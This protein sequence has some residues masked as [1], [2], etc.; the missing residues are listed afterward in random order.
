MILKRLGVD[1][2]LTEAALHEGLLLLPKTTKYFLYVAK[3]L[4]Y[5]TNLKADVEVEIL[6]DTDLPLNAWYFTNGFEG[7]FSF[8]A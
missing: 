8:G 5:S 7:I 6:M 3:D 4:D 2:D 1:S